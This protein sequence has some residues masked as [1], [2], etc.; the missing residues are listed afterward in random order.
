MTLTNAP[1]PDL[2]ILF[3]ACLGPALVVVALAV[4]AARLGARR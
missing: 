3:I 4:V 1:E 2:L